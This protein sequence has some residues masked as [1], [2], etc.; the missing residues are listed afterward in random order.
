MPL[1]LSEPGGITPLML[2]A[3][4]SPLTVSAPRNMLANPTMCARAARHPSLCARVPMGNLDTPVLVKRRSVAHQ[5][6]MADYLWTTVKDFNGRRRIS[7]TVDG[8]SRSKR[9]T[10]TI[11]LRAFKAGASNK[12]AWSPPQVATTIHKTCIARCFRS[13]CT[14]FRFTLHKIEHVKKQCF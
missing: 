5:T 13:G 11:A 6:V 12:S 10:L 2:S 7:L 8:S 9:D 14:F 1:T 3:L 4:G